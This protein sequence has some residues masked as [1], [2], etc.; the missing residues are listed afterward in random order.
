IVFVFP[1]NWV[2]FK[3]LQRIMHP[4]HHPLH[5]E[6]DSAVMYRRGKQGKVRTF[7]S[8]GKD[9][10]KLAVNDNIEFLQK[11]LGFKVY[12]TSEH[13]GYPLAH[14]TCI[15]KVEHGCNGIY[16]QAVGV[17][18][19]QPKHSV[20]NQKRFYFGTAIIEQIR[21]P[22]RMKALAWI[23]MFIEVSTV[24]NMKPV[25]IARE[26]RRH[27]VQYD[28]YIISVQFINQEHQ[29]L[30]RSE[31]GIR[32]KKACDLVTPA[33]LVRV[34]HHGHKFHMSKTHFFNIGYQSLS[35]FAVAQETFG[36]FSTAH[37]RT[38]VHFIYRN[39]RLQTVVFMSARHPF[40]VIPLVP[41]GRD[42]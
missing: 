22:L 23:F 41:G 2:L 26:V 40:R 27:P 39:R 37:P 5:P 8:N 17:I 19:V 9:I 38:Q 32:S 42:K 28:T 18:A 14:F 7:L 11:F 36:V 34:L 35:N 15:I 25:G 29:V 24:K 20:G 33:W 21:A 13:V 12:I 1:V 16:P 3:I 10:R 4:T 31:T 30:W 6:T